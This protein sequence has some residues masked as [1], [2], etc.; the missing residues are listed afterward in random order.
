MIKTVIR[1]RRV[2]H[3]ETKSENSLGVFGWK[4]KLCNVVATTLDNSKT[5]DEVKKLLVH[6]NP[7]HE[8]TFKVV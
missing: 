7:G 3:Y 1:M 2:N 5:V 4:K 6:E 8:V